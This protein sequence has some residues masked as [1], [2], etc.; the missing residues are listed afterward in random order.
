MRGWFYR[1][2]TDY[3]PDQQS[4]SEA[5]NDVENGTSQCVNETVSAVREEEEVSVK[6][7]EPRDK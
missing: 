4:N 5:G 3:F 1:S 7:D 2:S 6:V